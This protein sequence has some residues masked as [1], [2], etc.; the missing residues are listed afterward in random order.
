MLF[1]AG[2]NR[3]VGGPF[4]R[5]V[6]VQA[7]F[8][9]TVA[10]QRIIINLARIPL[11]VLRDRYDLTEQKFSLCRVDSAVLTRNINRWKLWRSTAGKNA[12]ESDYAKIGTV[13]E[14]RLQRLPLVEGGER[15]LNCPVTTDLSTANASRDS[16]FR[17]KR[18]INF[19]SW[20]HT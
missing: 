17:E 19:I 8:N 14:K 10:T 9:G 5:R 6:P 18:L 20:P 1:T 15:L 16:C 13:F 2:G 3:G 11:P 12:M 4:L 7:A